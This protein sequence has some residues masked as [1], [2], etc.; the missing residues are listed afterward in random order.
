LQR[1]KSSSP[2]K[3]RLNTSRPAKCAT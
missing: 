2:N 3:S 1:R